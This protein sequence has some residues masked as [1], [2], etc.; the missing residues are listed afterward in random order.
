[1][2]DI[3]CCGEPSDWRAHNLGSSNCK[4]DKDGREF[5]PYCNGTGLGEQAEH[6]PFGKK[7]KCKHCE[8]GHKKVIK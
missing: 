6:P 5:C 2:D 4:Y 3:C 1:M 8:D 7:D